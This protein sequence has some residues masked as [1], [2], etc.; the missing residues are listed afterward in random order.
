MK[1]AAAIL[2]CLAYFLGY[3]T[4]VNEGASET[5]DRYGY[6]VN[7]GMTYETPGYTSFHCPHGWTLQGEDWKCHNYWPSDTPKEPR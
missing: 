6:V 7:P 1:T 5:T 2:I 4:G 3:R